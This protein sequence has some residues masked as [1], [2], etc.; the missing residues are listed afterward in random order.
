MPS[1]RNRVWDYL[2]YLDWV[3]G[4]RIV[5]VGYLEASRLSCQLSTVWKHCEFKPLKGTGVNW[6]HFAIQV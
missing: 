4:E 2:T 1:T 5:G 6:L 3:W